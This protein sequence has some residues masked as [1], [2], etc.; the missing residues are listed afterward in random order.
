M[1]IFLSIIAFLFFGWLMY[2]ISRI[3]KEIRSEG[4]IEDYTEVEREVIHSLKTYISKKEGYNS[5][6][7]APHFMTESGD[8]SYQLFYSYFDL[9]ANNSRVGTRKKFELIKE[10]NVK[11]VP[12]L[13]YSE[14]HDNVEVIRRS[15]V[16]KK[17]DWFWFMEKF[18][19]IHLSAEELVNKRLNETS[20]TLFID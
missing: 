5:T 18:D 14:S 6:L 2:S 3:R 1:T 4:R 9:L 17:S 13:H 11:N 12:T 8:N 16:L 10:W 20:T 19:C 7:F 15:I